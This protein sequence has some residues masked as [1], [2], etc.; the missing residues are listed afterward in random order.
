MLLA[1]VLVISLIL[2]TPVTAAR[3]ISIY[4][5]GVK[6]STDQA[7]IMVQ[8]RTLL[9][10]RAIF[11]A[12][13]AQVLW[14][15]QTKIVTAIKDDT[16]IVLKIGSNTATINNSIVSLDV[17]AQ[18]V[19][20]RTM[21]PVRFVSEALGEEVNWNSAAQSVYITTLDQVN[22]VSYVNA[23]VISQLGDGRDLEVSFPKLS[24]ESGIDQ[25]RILVV[26]SSNAST[27]NLARAL[28]TSYYTYVVPQGQDVTLSL[29]S[30]TKDVDGDQIRANNTY[31]VYVL[32]VGR[33]YNQ[34]ALSNA[35]QRVTITASSPVATVTNVN[36][37]DV[38]DYGDGRD[39]YVSFTKPQNDGNI[40][41]YRIMV[42]K[43]K[44]ANKFDV[45]AANRVSG[46]N[47]TIVNKT[48]STMATQL[49][50]NSRDTS[51][52]LIKNGVSYTIYVLSVSSNSN[53]APNK[54]SNGSSPITLGKNAMESPA[55]NYVN[56]ISDYSDGRDLFVSFGRISDESKISSYR[57]FVVKSSNANNFNLAAANALSSN[58]YTTVAKTGYSISVSLNSNT[59]DVD[60]SFV[61]NGVSYRIFVMAVGTGYYQGNNALSSY[62]SA[63]T[64][65]Y[66]YNYDYDVSPAYNITAN[67]VNDFGDGRD[68]V[69]SFYRPNDESNISYYRIMVVKSSNAGSF[70]LSSANSVS[71]SNY[72][73]VPKTGYNISQVLASTAR[74]VDGS[75]IKNGISYR[76]FVLSVGYG[77]YNALSSYS[78][79]ITLSNNYSINPATNVSVTDVSDYND[80]RDLLVAFNRAD[81]ETNIGH[82]RIM[83][84]KSSNA[85]SFNLSSA[86]SISSSNYTAVP[87]TGYNISQVLAS[88]ARDVNGSPIKNGISY[89]V[90]VL[91]VGNGNYSGYNALSSPSPAIT[92][93]NNFN[94]NPVNNLK[95][96]DVSDYNDGR[97][98]LVTFNRADDETNIS[99]Y[100]I[101]VVKSADADRFNLSA[102]NDVSSSRYTIVSATGNNISQALASG[103]KDVDGEAI[104]NGVSYQV[105]VLS[106]GNGNYAGSNE[107]S[108]PSSEITLANNS[109]AAAVTKVSAKVVGNSGNAH[110]IEVSFDKAQDETNIAEYRIMVVKSADSNDFKLA[111][112]NLV[113]AENYTKAAKKGE[114]IHQQL[115]DTSKD[116]KGN[117][118]AKGVPYRIFVLS[119]ADGKISAINAL[120]GP[121]A[122]FTLPNL[123]AAPVSE[124]TAVLDE[125]GS[126][127]KINFNKPENEASI[128][129][130]EVMV[131]PSGDSENFS[132][133][134]ANKV[135]SDN[136]KTVK[137]TDELPITLT[138]SDKDI[139]GALIRS[140]VA[141]KVFVL[142]IA[143]GKGATVNSLSSPSE[144][145]EIP[146]KKQSFRKR[147]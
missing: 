125:D 16:T 22:P 23:R 13:N 62:S 25:Y 64:L 57:I 35:S 31:L 91:A 97:D 48:G 80:G 115:P 76:V 77:N 84:V 54:L 120:A 50:S 78:P 27:F 106:V 130:Y 14:N 45:G 51:G 95:V 6:L 12:L 93:T 100:R 133:S 9:P 8:G 81:D 28:S 129:S 40:S 30:Q 71:S 47:Y 20:G 126:S 5:D 82:Y 55:I 109:A 7:P 144:E 32:S 11:E 99:H 61:T 66:N 74:D 70:T 122:Q 52:D 21:I 127:F 75:P 145:I 69:V 58:Y 117:S 56:D 10:L 110:D 3:A 121:S 65:Y 138:S 2:Q 19:N 118:I 114:D 140:G 131:V 73:A 136:Y 37:G 123:A 49:S 83:V 36:A 53:S 63:I 89:R 92:L 104:K 141:Y 24:K 143:D 124:V 94:I 107:L 43:T 96:S 59:R 111:D 33:G 134:D 38:S 86:N 147:R 39:L 137:K 1:S 72:T 102:A 29:S 4:I 108:A 101:L 112:A 128:S 68:L 88:T 46:S 119:V 17:P 139:T 116:I 41:N 113:T 79:A 146:L 132:L 85:G 60:G 34:N 67:D 44:D 18:S 90:F 142:S 135:I 103:A 105:F 42:V 98:L 26:K 87:K 15:Q